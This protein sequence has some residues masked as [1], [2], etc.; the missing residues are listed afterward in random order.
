MI[1][2]QMIISSLCVADSAAAKPSLRVKSERPSLLILLFHVLFKDSCEIDGNHLHPQQRM[3]VECFRRVIEYFL[4]TGY[5]FASPREVI[6]G[7]DPKKKYA[8]VTFDDGYFNN[9]RALPVLCEFDVPAV[10]YVSTNH[11]LQGKSFWWDI[12]YREALQDNKSPE[13]IEKRLGE[14][15]KWKNADIEAEL[16]RAIGPKGMMPQNDIDRPLTE[17]EL[18]DFARDKHVH[19]GNHTADHAILTNYE[20][21][22]AEQ[23]IEDCQESLREIL[24]IEAESIAYPNGCYNYQ[25]LEISR[26][27]GLKHGV[28]VEP[29]KNAFSLGKAPLK[30][31]HQGRFVPWA[32]PDVDKQCELFRSDV[33]PSKWVR[34]VWRL[35]KAVRFPNLH[36]SDINL[37]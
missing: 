2:R 10:F 20:P 13:E 29:C 37:K 28:S 11:V 34:Q 35:L 17:K 21:E 27:V 15:K 1:M 30:I 32:R 36:K 25:V 9:T 23:Q 31:M 3:T 4:E 5:Y 14:F 8:M 16:K 33:V 19:I 12:V 6:E 18:C 24:G 7:L 26:K 22:E